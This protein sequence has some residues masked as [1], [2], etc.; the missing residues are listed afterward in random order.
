MRKSEKVVAIIAIMF[1]A[2]MV[3]SWVST[4]VMFILQ[5]LKKFN[6]SVLDCIDFGLI[7]SVLVSIICAGLGFMFI[8]MNYVKHRSYKNEEKRL[9][10][11]IAST[12]RYISEMQKSIDEQ[13]PEV[14]EEISTLE[15]KISNLDVS[16]ISEDDGKKLSEL[17]RLCLEYLSVVSSLKNDLVSVC[18]QSAK[19][20]DYDTCRDFMDYNEEK[21]STIKARYFTEMSKKYAE[22]EKEYIECYEKI[23]SGLEDSELR[24]EI[25]SSLNPEEYK[26]PQDL[27][28]NQI[29][30]LDLIV[31]LAVLKENMIDVKYRTSEKSGREILKDLIKGEKD[32]TSRED[33]EEETGQVPPSVSD[34]NVSVVIEGVQRT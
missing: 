30:Y 4:V 10:G 27:I 1:F 13:L 9:S 33:R 14:E 19:N 29:T 15:E 34:T 7:P 3:I 16:S 31:T 17:K 25:I 5:D 22:M 28:K 24:S 11:A 18:R 8:C 26:F 23:I 6:L 12:E 32:I 21:I 20:A 2:A